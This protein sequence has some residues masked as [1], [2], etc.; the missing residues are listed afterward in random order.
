MVGGTEGVNC[1]HA[2]VRLYHRNPFYS[3]FRNKYNGTGLN[4]DKKILSFRNI[5]EWSY[6][7]TSY[8]KMTHSINGGNK[9][10]KKKSASVRSP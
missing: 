7:K 3:S 9:L 5:E 8:S 4:M 1:M 10:K 6:S 2:D